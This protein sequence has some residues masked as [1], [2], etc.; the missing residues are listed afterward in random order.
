M[1][2]PAACDSRAVEME[3]RAVVAVRAPLGQIPPLC[4]A[5]IRLYWARLLSRASKQSWPTGGKKQPA[6]QAG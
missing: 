6:K 3:A 5:A 2:L 1:V 4:A